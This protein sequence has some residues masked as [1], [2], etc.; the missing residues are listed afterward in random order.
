MRGSSLHPFPHACHHS[1]LPPPPAFRAN[2]FPNQTDRRA[3]L[4]ASTKGFTVRA[5]RDDEFTVGINA[6]FLISAIICGI[7]NPVDANWYSCADMVDKI[8][9]DRPGGQNMT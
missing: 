2:N 4:I 7:T 6:T 9:E 5:E 1:I 3:R 8:F